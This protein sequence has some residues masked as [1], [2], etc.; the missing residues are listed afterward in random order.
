ML[1]WFY[2]SFHVSNLLFLTNSMHLVTSSLFNHSFVKILSPKSRV[3]LLRTY[4]AVTCL[5]WVSRGRP[6][7]NIKNFYESTTPNPQPPNTDTVKPDPET[8]DPK[9][10]TPNAWLPILQTTLQHP[11][12]HLPKFQRALS[13]YSTWYG[14]TE[15]GYWKDRAGCL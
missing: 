4:F 11:N 7:I 2:S 6:I 15:K 12:E 14:T 1:I 9:N 8:L 10:L 13:L 5:V 3:I